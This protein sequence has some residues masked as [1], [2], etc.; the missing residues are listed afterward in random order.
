MLKLTLLPDEYLTINGD[1][2]VQLKRARHEAGI[3]PFGGERLRRG[4]GG[5][6]KAAGPHHPRLLGGRSG[7]AIMFLIS[8]GFANRLE[9]SPALNGPCAQ[10]PRSLGRTALHPCAETGKSR[11]A[12]NRNPT[13][14]FY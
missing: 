7:R 14:T 6:A 5:P 9:Y 4:G 10:R 13:T 11:R 8:P 2:V 3:R 12:K 1:I